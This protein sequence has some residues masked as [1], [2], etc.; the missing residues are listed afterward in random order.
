[1]ITTMAQLETTLR[2]ASTAYISEKKHT[3]ATHYKAALEYVTDNHMEDDVVNK[4]IIKYVLNLIALESE[5]G[6]DLI[7]AVSSLSS[8]ETC[9]GD[10]FPAIYYALAKAHSKLFRFEL[11]DE[12][13]KKGF[14]FL[15]SDKELKEY[16]FP[17]TKT[18][19]PESTKK[20]LLEVLMQLKEECSG[21]HRPDA[22]CSSQNCQNFT[23]VHSIPNRNIFFSD[24]TFTGMVRVTCNN[25]SHPCKVNYHQVC[26]K[27]IKEQLSPV[28]KI[29]DKDVI[30][31][32]CFT[33]NCE[34]ET[35]PSVIIKIEVIGENAEVK[36]VIEGPAALIQPPKPPPIAKGA[37]RKQ[38]QQPKEKRRFEKPKRPPTVPH[39]TPHPKEPSIEKDY[40]GEQ[41]LSLVALRENNFGISP[42]HDWRPDREMYGNLNLTA[43]GDAFPDPDFSSS[44]PEIAQI[45]SFTFSMLYEYIVNNG[46]VR[47]KDVLQKWEDTKSI[48]PTSVNIINNDIEIIDFLLQSLKIAMVGDYICTSRMLPDVYR[49]IKQNTSGCLKFAMETAI[50]PEEI[51]ME[52]D[53][54]FNQIMQEESCGSSHSSQLP[55]V[56]QYEKKQSSKKVAPAPKLDSSN[57]KIGKSKKLNKKPKIK[58]PKGEEPTEEMLYQGI[59]GIY[60]QLESFNPISGYSISGLQMDYNQTDYNQ[61]DYNQTDYNQT[62][63]NQID[64]S[65]YIPTDEADAAPDVEDEVLQQIISNSTPQEVEKSQ[66]IQNNFQA[67]NFQ[68]LPENLKSSAQNESVIEEVRLTVKNFFEEFEQKILRKKQMA[69]GPQGD[70]SV[71]DEKYNA[72]DDSRRGS[73]IS[74]ENPTDASGKSVE[75]ENEVYKRYTE[76]IAQLNTEIQ[77]LSRQKT[78]AEQ[79]VGQLMQEKGNIIKSFEAER[80]HLMEKVKVCSNLVSTTKDVEMRY[81]SMKKDF[82]KL[83]QDTTAVVTHKKELELKLENSAKEKEAIAEDFENQYLTLAM[84]MGKI[85]KELDA[86]TR[87]LENELEARLDLKQTLLQKCLNAQFIAN[88]NL[89][90]GYMEQCK[91]TLEV[92]TAANAF[93]K[94]ALNISLFP[95]A[96][97]WAKTLSD[98][99][100]VN[101]EHQAEFS[102]LFAILQSKEEVKSI[103]D[104]SLKLNDVPAK[105]V[106]SLPESIQR[107]FSV[108]HMHFMKMIPPRIPNMQ[109]PPPLMHPVLGQPMFIQNP[110]QAY[111]MNSGYPYPR[112]RLPYPPLPPQQQQQQQQQQPVPAQPGLAPFNFPRPGPPSPNNNGNGILNNNKITSSVSSTIVKIVDDAETKEQEESV[113]GSS[114]NLNVSL[115]EVLIEEKEKLSEISSIGGSTTSLSAKSESAAT[116]PL[117]GLQ[118]KKPKYGIDRVM[119]KLR[120]EFLGVPELDLIESISEIRKM[121]NNSLNGMRTSE[122][123]KEA[124]QFIV[125]R[126]RQHICDYTTE[127][128][129]PEPKEEKQENP[130]VV[131]SKEKPPVENKDYFHPF[132]FERLSVIRNRQNSLS[133]TSSVGSAPKPESKKKT[134]SKPA[135]V[136]IKSS[137]NKWKKE[138]QEAECNICMDPLENTGFKKAVYTLRCQH[139]FHTECIRSWF[140]QS[141]SCPTCRVFSTLDDDFPPLPS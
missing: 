12:A 94:N 64:F 61:T 92:F 93:L 128:T 129:Q 54:V 23:Q 53:D 82:T 6:D 25:C 132:A 2:N 17:G 134:P 141:Q 72:A 81:E 119:Q 124:R 60:A 126:Q 9:I 133:S 99:Q 89:L 131:L 47:V 139:A 4:D 86:K 137:D 84:E 14:A 55:P 58:T 117:N 7:T 50:E 74:Q 121:H 62:D 21:W 111:V 24:P 101:I 96:R 90:T 27:T 5:K 95:E 104:I 88:K 32:E 135:W 15:N 83:V 70:G 49:T 11:A 130:E 39:Q 136:P 36:T 37:I 118:L 69:M 33:P 46:P 56:P 76:H 51:E 71:I 140:R 19:L 120:T 42:E 31:F 73:N 123:V 28:E 87:E 109:Q 8:L 59:Q 10:K 35:T 114:E 57:M 97:E 79:K 40:I 3:A 116:P 20:G 125:K 1:M 67:N 138:A 29:S 43:I 48:M 22:I 77:N 122:I 108:L 80:D 105:P 41:I 16:Y 26:W 65:Q 44:E 103:G 106:I 85:S 78:L 102:K 18:V 63:Y 13:V 112:N 107:A 115:D 100:T 98:L 110:Q 52:D 68:E 34:N 45:E 127:N 66:L 91:L 113:Q 30:G 38:T 75:M